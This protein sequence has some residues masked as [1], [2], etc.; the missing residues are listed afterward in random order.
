MTHFWSVF[1]G[2]VQTF[3]VVF[4]FMIWKVKREPPVTILY[5]KSDMLMF[6]PKSGSTRSHPV[7]ICL[8]RHSDLP[9]F[10]PSGRWRCRSSHPSPRSAGAKMRFDQAR[11][12]QLLL[13]MESCPNRLELS[14][15]KK[16]GR[17][18]VFTQ[19]KLS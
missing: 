8:P 9:V 16:T 11:A 18:K 17:W 14:G 10:P 4:T 13:P 12:C 2:V 19:K 1:F 15:W 5:I 3:L 7:Q 6:Q